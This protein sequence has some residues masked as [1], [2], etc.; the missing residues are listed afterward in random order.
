MRLNPRQSFPTTTR[1]LRLQEWGGLCLWL[2]GDWLRPRKV[3]FSRAR[4]ITAVV[5]I[6][7]SAGEA[8]R[9]VTPLSRD[10]YSTFWRGTESGCALSDRWRRLF[11]NSETFPLFNFVLKEWEGFISEERARE[12]RVNDLQVSLIS[13]SALLFNAE[14]AWRHSS[15]VMETKSWELGLSSRDGGAGQ[16]YWL[17]DAINYSTL[18]RSELR[19]RSALIFFLIWLLFLQASWSTS[20][21]KTLVFSRFIFTWGDGWMDGCHPQLYSSSVVK[22]VDYCW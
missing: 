3:L 10:F 1:L 21:F 22:M 7:L 20:D 19:Y 4:Y 6:S 9:L 8:E 15:I 11:Q 14:L 16:G 18:F 2:T 12:K 17:G 13:T 5:F